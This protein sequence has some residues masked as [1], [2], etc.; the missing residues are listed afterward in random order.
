M[1]F[2]KISTFLLIWRIYKRLARISKSLLDK[3]VSTNT[4]NG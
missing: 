4:L 2:K 1:R 3:K